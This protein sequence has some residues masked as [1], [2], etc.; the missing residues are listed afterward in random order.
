M[1]REKGLRTSLESRGGGGGI[2]T[3][4]KRGFPRAVLVPSVKPWLL[5][6]ETTKTLEGGHNIGDLWPCHQGAYRLAQAKEDLVLGKATHWAGAEEA[7][8]SSYSDPTLIPARKGYRFIDL[9]TTGAFEELDFQEGKFRVTGGSAS[10]AG[11]TLDIAYNDASYAS[12]DISGDSD[13]YITRIYFADPLIIDLDADTDWHLQGNMFACQRQSI[14]EDQDTDHPRLHTG[15]PTVPVEADEYF[16]LQVAGPATGQLQ[17]SIP[18]AEVNNTFTDL[19]PWRGRG[20]RND[21]ED[22]GKFQI[23]REEVRNIGYFNWGPFARLL[24]RSIPSGGFT[25]DSYVPVWLYGETAS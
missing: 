25:A 11:I 23:A 5:L 21:L 13:R 18:R 6:T 17:E 9:E 2:A 14:L 22:V 12:D 4:R 20:D 8:T 16:W 3:S 24:T 7:R 19:N 15:L 1:S 10:I